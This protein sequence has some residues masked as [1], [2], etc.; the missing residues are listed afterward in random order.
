MDFSNLKSEQEIKE[1]IEKGKTFI[2]SQSMASVL[3]LTN[4]SNM[5]FNN[6][7]KELFTIFVK[8]NK[9]YVK[10]GAVIGISGLQGIVYNA[11]MKLSGRNLKSMRSVDE[12]KDWLAGNF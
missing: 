8:D 2:R 4:I 9:S 11:V 3:T 10:A 12:A 5:H 6:Q 7:I 1:I